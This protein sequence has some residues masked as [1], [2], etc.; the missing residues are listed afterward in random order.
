MCR[1]NSAF[2]LLAMQSPGVGCPAW[3]QRCVGARWLHARVFREYARVRQ[4][5]LGPWLRECVRLS[6]PVDPAGFVALSCIISGP[7]M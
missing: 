3:N 4:K 7:L 6:L 5:H 1:Q 2:C